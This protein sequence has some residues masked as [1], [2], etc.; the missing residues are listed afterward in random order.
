MDKNK[1]TVM[2]FLCSSSG[3]NS[4]VPLIEWYSSA[5][6]LCPDI[7]KEM[8]NYAITGKFPCK[9]QAIQVRGIT[10]EELTKEGLEPL[11]AYKKL[12]SIKVETY[13]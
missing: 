7:I 5:E 4:T 2:K 11:E 13:A 3:T 12:I 1:E 8:N 9:K 6:T 10:A